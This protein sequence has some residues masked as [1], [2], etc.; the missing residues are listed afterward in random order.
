MILKTHTQ[1]IAGMNNT[2]MLTVMKRALR[3]PYVMQLALKADPA[4]LEVSRWCNDGEDVLPPEDPKDSPNF[5]DLE[6][7]VGRL[8]AHVIDAEMHPM[9]QL[10]AAMQA[11]RATKHTPVRMV[12]P[13]GGM[14]SAFLGVSDSSDMPYC[15]GVPVSY[16]SD[17]LVQ[18]KILLVGSTSEYL[19]DAAS[20]AILDL[21]A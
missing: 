17:P 1:P 21:G 3:R 2:E 16:V 10:F 19:E 4:V 7:L 9:H 15:F 8:E 13:P 14:L 5:L 12:A 6:F 18:E 20:V 11:I